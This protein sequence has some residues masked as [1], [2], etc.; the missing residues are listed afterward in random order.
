MSVATVSQ[1]GNPSPDSSFPSEASEA[2]LLVESARE[3]SGEAFVESRRGILDIYASDF[4]RAPASRRLGGMRWRRSGQYLGARPDISPC[5]S[6]LLSL[7]QKV[8]MAVGIAMQAVE[9]KETNSERP[10]RTS[11]RKAC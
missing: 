7:R 1:S 5:V 8:K 9:A 11:P 3:E 10:G 4:K 6:K 2:G